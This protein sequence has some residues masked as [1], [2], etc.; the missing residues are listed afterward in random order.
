MKKI[1][2]ALFALVLSVPAFAQ[3]TKQVPDIPASAPCS[4]V[5]ITS[6]GPTG[7]FTMGAVE[8]EKREAARLF[9]AAGQLDAAI[10]ILCSTHA[11]K[12]AYG[13]TWD[14]AEQSGNVKQTV[15]LK[16]LQSSAYFEA[17]G[18]LFNAQGAQ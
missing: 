10:R 15:S 8:C 2:L 1:A 9:I 12:V 13:E 16:C 14:A 17:Q 11:A 18:N 7:A 5:A 3:T 6:L 4:G